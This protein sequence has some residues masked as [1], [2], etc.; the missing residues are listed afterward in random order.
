VPDIPASSVGVRNG[1][2][3]GAELLAVCVFGAVVFLPGLWSRDLWH[4][5]EPRYAQVAHEI[6]T[7][8][9][10]VVLHLNGEPYYNKPPLLFWLAALSIK[11]LGRYTLAVRL[12]VLLFGVGCLIACYL[13]ALSLGVNP[14]LASLVLG[15]SMRF[16]WAA[17]RVT[18]DVILTFFVL[19]AFYLY[20]RSTQQAK[21]WWLYFGASSLALGFA[22]LTKGPVA[23]L[24][25]ACAIVPYL[26]WQRNWKELL[27][28]KWLAG[29]AIA[30][31]PVM[32]W[33]VPVVLLKGRCVIDIALWREV[34]ARAG[35][36][37]ARGGIHYYLRSLPGEFLPWVVYL[38]FALIYVCQRPGRSGAFR[39]VL[40]LAAALLVFSLLPAKADRYL[41]PLLP[42]AAITVAA[43]LDER[44]HWIGRVLLAL[45]LAA[46]VGLAVCAARR[47]A[48]LPWALGLAVPVG[49]ASL[50]GWILWRRMGYRAV[51][52][53]AVIGLVAYPLTYG[54]DADT[55]KSPVLLAGFL[56]STGA[57]AARIIWVGGYEAG[58]AFHAGFAEMPCVD[59]IGSLDE[60]PASW[61][62]V[63]GSVVQASPEVYAG[64]E[65]VREFT[66]ARATYY[67]YAPREG[68]EQCVGPGTCAYP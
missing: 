35:G 41:I 18:T 9:D 22:L 26:V 4:P 56:Q 36:Y 64:A 43:Y 48:M 16:V 19:M 8:G 32:A 53:A 17:Q 62:A 54:A 25:L 42:P 55:R 66:I 63:L 61:L 14:V 21:R 6:V 12:P 2:S 45:L 33:L 1:R 57:P 31:L 65:P 40:W 58:V 7:R 5:L 29:L 23:L 37:E 49:L 44:D 20:L 30:S 47:P 60:Y 52:G 10:W 39:L 15:T 68:P 3:V 34:I 59:A 24:M 13:V 38:P 67:V 46:S 11:A 51:L 28:W 27:H 50:A